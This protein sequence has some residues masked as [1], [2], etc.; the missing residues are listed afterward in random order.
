[1]HSSIYYDAWNL[2]CKKP[3]GAVPENIET[4]IS[5]EV[6]TS[7]HPQGLSLVLRKDGS[8][9]SKR[10]FFSQKIADNHSI[11]Y[12]TTFSVEKEGLYFYRFEIETGEGILFVGKGEG[13]TAAIG[14]FLPEWQLTVYQQNFETPSWPQNGLMY[15]I[16][17]DRFYRSEKSPLRP[18]KNQR[19]LHSDWYERPLFM[20]DTPE[21]NATD[22]FGGNLIGI[23]EKL[24]Y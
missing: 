10:L 24:P 21:Y 12:Q 15:Q 11:T 16:F 5:F 1:M 19:F 6:N 4:T 20:Q 22:F 8:E 9:E 23:T 3:F 18:S 13:A 7:L 2:A 17:P 14:D